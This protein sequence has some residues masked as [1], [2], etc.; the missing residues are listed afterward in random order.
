MASFSRACAFARASR[1]PYAATS[2][3][4]YW[5]PASSVT[6]STSQPSPPSVCATF[7]CTVSSPSELGIGYSGPVGCSLRASSLIAYAWAVAAGLNV[8]AADGQGHH[9]RCR[10]ASSTEP[11]V[12]RVTPLP[13]LS[14]YVRST[15]W[16]VTTS[17][18]T[19]VPA[20]SIVAHTA[21]VVASAR[22]RTCR[23]EGAATHPPPIR[24]S[25]PVP[26]HSPRPRRPYRS[27]ADL[28]M[29]GRADTLGSTQRTPTPG[30]VIPPRAPRS[31]WLADN[32]AAGSV[33]IQ[34]PQSGERFWLPV[35]G[36][37]LGRPRRSNLRLTHT[38]PFA[39]REVAEPRHPGT[40][41]RQPLR[42]AAVAGTPAGWRRRAGP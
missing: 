18:E 39:R 26:R 15:R 21:M 17:A 42:R 30:A 10:Q 20:C 3:A 27:A 31:G 25:P 8:P 22:N 16:Y 12:R 7:H 4:W 14:R 35:P 19:G 23:A 37:G 34:P 5:P 28:A 29:G 36:L 13:A 33:T 40:Q 6:T 2:Y 11:R 9:R 24:T 41:P 32:P 1:S 38:F